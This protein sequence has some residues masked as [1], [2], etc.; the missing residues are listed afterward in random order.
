MKQQLGY[1]LIRDEKRAQ[2]RKELQTDLPGGLT[3]LGKTSRACVV[4]LRKQSL[5]QE[6]QTTQ[7]QPQ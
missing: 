4:H 7:A 3:S 1:L 6:A 2:L 5:L